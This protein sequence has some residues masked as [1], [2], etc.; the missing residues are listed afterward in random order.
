MRGFSAI[1][2]SA[3]KP[4]F[5]VARRIAVVHQKLRWLMEVSE[6]RGLAPK[7]APDSKLQSL[8]QNYK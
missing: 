2:L 4:L 5:R 7:I 3:P 6:R 1:G 8:N